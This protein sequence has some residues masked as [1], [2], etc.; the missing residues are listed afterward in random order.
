MPAIK[1]SNYVN[2]V[3][4]IMENDLIFN[5]IYNE[6]IPGIELWS[7]SN[8][9]N[10]YS[11]DYFERTPLI[12]AVNMEKSLIVEWLLEHGA[13][14]YSRNI[15]DDTAFHLAA[16]KGLIFIVKNF[17]RLGY[18]IDTL[19]QDDMTGLNYAIQW[20]HDE[21]AAYLISQGASLSIPDSVFKLNAKDRII[22]KNKIFLLDFKK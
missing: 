22:K 6:D 14:M 8:N 2:K 5:L 18:E 1:F 3:N 21:V 17:C 16:K 11:E 9:I 7:K 13:D 4:Y 15:F 10:I 20:D 12:Y 19:G